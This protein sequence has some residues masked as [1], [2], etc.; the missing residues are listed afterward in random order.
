VDD[1]AIIELYWTRSE[2]AIN[3]TAKKYGVYCKKVAMNILN[4]QED[5]EECVNDTYHKTWDAI[6]PQRPELFSSFLG[7]ITRNISLNRYK[8]QRTAKRGGGEVELLL[9]ELEDCIPSNR[10]VEAEYE[11]GCV[12]KAIEDFL[13]LAGKEIRL[14]FV[15]RYW[16]ADSISAISERYS[17]SKSNVK[18]ILHRTRVKLR[19]HFEKEGIEI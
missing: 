11:A 9:D 3:E 18:T 13:Y 6:P 7:R 5:S 10:S 16:Y 19:E 12:T 15:R 1:A 4:N 14:V 17:I 2:S 8:A